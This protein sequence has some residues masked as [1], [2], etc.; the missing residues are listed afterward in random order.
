MSGSGVQRCFPQ[1]SF[2][3]LESC[4]I[5]ENTFNSI[6]KCDVDIQK[7]LYV[8]VVLSIGTTMYSGIAR[9]QKLITALAPSMMKIKIMAPPEHKY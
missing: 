9:M 5:H 6:I 7:D 4:G 8:N 1:S 3:G 2:L